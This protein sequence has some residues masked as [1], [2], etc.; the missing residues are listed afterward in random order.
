MATVICRFMTSVIWNNN[1]LADDLRQY[2]EV[3][4][5]APKRL[6]NRSP[7]CV[8]RALVTTGV[9]P[10][11]SL[12]Q[13]E[14]AGDWAGKTRAKRYPDRNN[15][16]KDVLN[17]HITPDSYDYKYILFDCTKMYI[18]DLYVLNNPGCA[19]ELEKHRYFSWKKWPRSSGWGYKMNRIRR[20]P[21]LP[22]GDNKS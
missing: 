7:M 4:T 13:L 18:H 11:V 9:N 20:F 14:R 17:M 15:W 16:P 21:P 2:R 19:L 12:R 1:P 10:L 5:H 6:I 8:C 22:R 3:K